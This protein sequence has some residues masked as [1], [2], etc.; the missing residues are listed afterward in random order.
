[1]TSSRNGNVLQHELIQRIEL[2]KH[3]LVA[4]PSAKKG[5]ILPR[6]KGRKDMQTRGAKIGNSRPDCCDN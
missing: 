4:W 5:S 2:E 1:M 6:E 3:I